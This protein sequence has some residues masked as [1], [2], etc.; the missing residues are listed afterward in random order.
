M[1]PSPNRDP[2]AFLESVLDIVR[3]HHIR[4]VIPVSDTAVLTI[5]RNR[6]LFPAGTRLAIPGSDAI[7]KVIDKR[8]NIEIARS[9]G[10]PCPRQFEAADISEV[11]KM[12][13]ELKLPVVL[14]NPAYGTDLGKAFRFR[15]LFAE[16]EGQ[17]RQYV[18]EYCVADQLPLFQECVVGDV[19]NLCCF[20]VQGQTVAVHAYRSLRRLDGEG[21]LREIVAPIPILEEYARRLLR[22][23]RWDGVAHL[24]FFLSRDEDPDGQKVWYME[25]NGRPW[26]SLQGS[27][28][29]GWDF[30]LWIYR[31]F[32]HGEVP[33]PAPI[34]VGSRTCWH[35]GD[36]KALLEY[37]KGGGPATRTEPGAL[38]AVLSYLAGFS[39]RVHSDTFRLDDPLPAGVE[40]WRYLAALLKRAARRPARGR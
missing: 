13:E 40:H 5:D 4:L 7:A 23:L 18:Q 16:S 32:L 29:G 9:L 15:V 3:A 12:I 22:E 27:V 39:P 11:S 24:G 26:A 1:A 28:N 19:Y 33:R 2:E 35:L 25:T 14:K 37:L 36:L 21:V 10:I 31:Y 30:P 6:Q 8:R 20:A 34:S 17:V 38:R